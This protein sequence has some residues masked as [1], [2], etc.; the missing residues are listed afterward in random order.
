[1]LEAD[2]SPGDIISPVDEEDWPKMKNL[3]SQ[4][5]LLNLFGSV[6]DMTYD[7]MMTGGFQCLVNNTELFE[8]TSFPNVCPTGQGIF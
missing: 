4:Q 7:R 6:H 5:N 8:G 3:L 1:V 2:L